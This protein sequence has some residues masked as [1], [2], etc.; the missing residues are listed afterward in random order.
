MELALIS[1]VA[2]ATSILTF[3]SGF[4]LGTLLM[5]IIAL[6]FPLEVAITIT[7][8][9][10]LANNI[11]KTVLVGKY[12]HWK[13]L[14]KFGITAIIAAFFGAQLLSWLSENTTVINF[15]ILNY[16]F[17]TTLLRLIIGM[18]I[19]IFVILEFTPQF[20]KLQFNQ[21]YLPLGGLI[22]GFFGGLSG[23]QG[24]FRSLFLI[25]SGLT[26]EQFIATGVL[27]AVMIDISRLSVYSW[28]M[29][30]SS[31]NI[32]W[33]LVISAS[34]SAF[35]GAYIGRQL[36]KKVTIKTVHALVSLLLIVVS[37]SLILGII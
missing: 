27:I 20:S 4:G 21:K 28:N 18:L 12:A 14:L 7:A 34:L 26:K 29:H 23:H 5:P 16:V 6:F 11:F 25:K 19:L 9:V 36:L 33:I 35:I 30:V 15:T 10:H 13:V 1:I 22:S 2:F 17:G 31:V 32:D 8:I 37:L 3:F 24:A